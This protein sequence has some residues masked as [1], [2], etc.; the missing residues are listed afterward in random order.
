MLAGARAGDV[1]MRA[2]QQA[3]VRAR[4]CRHAVGAAPHGLFERVIR[5]L[6]AH[7]NIEL[8]PA[9]AAFLEAGGP[10]CPRQKAAFSTMY[11]LSTIRRKSFW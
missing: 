3:R 11:A 4:T 2:L 6:L 7:H 10:R 5:Y 1:T 8:H 9:N